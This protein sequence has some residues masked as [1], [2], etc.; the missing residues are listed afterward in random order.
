L[1]QAFPEITAVQKS[2]HR[3]T[4]PDE[5][6][7]Y[8]IPDFRK[9]FEAL[10]AERL[11]R[12]SGTILGNDWIKAFPVPFDQSLNVIVNGG[13]TGQA[14]LQLL[15][16]SGRLIEAREVTVVTGQNRL[17]QFSRSNYLPVGM[18]FIRYGDAARKATI[19]VIKVK[20]L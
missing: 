9:A 11:L 2:S 7:G 6:F 16:A 18:Y 10:S 12:N 19:K 13:T 17:V 3:Y 8:G 14:W 15:D 4:N 1:W 20:K 5:R